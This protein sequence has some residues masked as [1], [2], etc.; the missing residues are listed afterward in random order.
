LE[1][2]AGEY[3]LATN[4]GLVRFNPKAQP[5]NQV[6]Y[7]SETDSRPQAM[8]TVILPE[9]DDRYARVVTVLLED[10]KGAIWCGTYN[11]LYLLERS[12]TNFTLREIQ[13][14]L[15]GGEG[16]NVSD[17]FEDR[18]G[19]LWVATPGGLSRRWTD[20][21]SAL[22]RIRDGL[23]NDYL[24]DLFEDHNGQLWVGT[25]YG[26]FF[27]FVA[28]D[29]HRPPVIV[30]KY[31][32]AEGMPTAWVF[33]LFETSDNRFWVATA[34]GILQ[35]FPNRDE[36]G[37]WFHSYTEKNG[38]SYHDITALNEDL[39]GNLW[40]GTNSKG[41]MK[42][43]RNGFITYDR[44]DGLYGVN[45][46][47]GERAGGV[48]FRGSVMGDDRTSVFEGAKLDT[49]GHTREYYYTRLGRFDGQALTWFR[50]NLVKDLG[51]IGEGVTLQTRNGEWWV[52]TGDGLYR[53]PP[54]DRF[55][56]IKSAR[57]LA[58]YTSKDGIGV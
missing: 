19:S 32:I 27:Q 47:F 57:P 41:A 16:R 9:G 8:F 35:F 15:L 40:M 1:T 46:I 58:V 12:T 11:G 48:C 34:K 10:H 39:A 33:Q 6:I 20:G 45:S 54:S 23:P 51:W 30:R 36:Q 17:L 44:N 26:G 42:L 52:G 29:T 24:H 4:A 28:D 38:L 3:W 22:Y 31:S 21:S 5:Q 2:R 53:F 43:E 56:Q 49:K 18:G 25:R 7:S 14:G 55:D 50:P 37:S 13:I